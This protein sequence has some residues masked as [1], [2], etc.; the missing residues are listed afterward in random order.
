MSKN[1]IIITL[2][3][4]IYGLMFADLFL[5]FH[6]LIRVRKI[7]KW[8]W[9]PL[10]SAWYLFLTI[11]YN[12]WGLSSAQNST[13]SIS[14]YLFLAH[15]HLLLLTF[16]LVSTALPDQIDKN[17]ID[18]K[19]YYFK[20]HRYFWGLMSSVV[21]ISILINFFKQFHRLGSL[22]I[23]FTFLTVS[24]LPILTITLAISKRYWVHATILIILVIGIIL[25][26]FIR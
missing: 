10:L 1:D 25:E 8:H 9:L 11:L 17:G 5:S 13:G 7:V 20:N 23:L 4:I 26:I 19:T 3:T 14:I 6:K 18:L 24:I 2:F 22:N 12:W 21:I 16:L 15:G